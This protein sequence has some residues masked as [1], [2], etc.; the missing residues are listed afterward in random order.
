MGEGG[1]NLRTRGCR[2]WVL[3]GLLG[4]AGIT[5]LAVG[6][7]LVLSHRAPS[8]WRVIDT[9]DPSLARV[10]QSVENE[11]TTELSRVREGEDWRMSLRTTP[12]NAWL[13]SRLGPWAT[14]QAGLKTWPAEIAEVQCDFAQGRIAL[15]VR[16]RLGPSPGDGERI[17][18]AQVRPWIDERGALW[19]PAESF[20]VGRLP[21]PTSWALRLIDGGSSIGLPESVRSAPAVATLARALAG[22]APLAPSV[23]LKLPDGRRVRVMRLESADGELTVT[24]R[25]LD[26]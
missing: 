2:R 3:L 14:S 24:C 15:A 21:L 18:T 23:I 13:N 19:V 12:A 20:A 25:T 17:I 5:A 22:E 6:A 11:L 4:L 7:A 10:G 26:R 8:W 1:Q 9:A 16:V